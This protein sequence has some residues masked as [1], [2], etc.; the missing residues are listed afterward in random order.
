MVTSDYCGEQYSLFGKGGQYGSYN[1]CY[2]NHILRKILF[3]SVEKVSVIENFSTPTNHV[4]ITF[5]NAVSKV[6][7]IILLLIDNS[8]L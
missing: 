3:I 7:V 5:V 4:F 6:F 1:S 2:K 8:H